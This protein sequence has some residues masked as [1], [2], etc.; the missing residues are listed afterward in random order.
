M[1]PGHC[2]C[3]WVVGI[4]VG[5][6]V[7]VPSSPAIVVHWQCRVVACVVAWLCR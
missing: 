3:H 5:W 4:V 1:G 2:L 6:L 7:D